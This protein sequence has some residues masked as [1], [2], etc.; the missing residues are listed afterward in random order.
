MASKTGLKAFD[1][2]Q[3]R[4]VREVCAFFGQAQSPGLKK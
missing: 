3:G 1:P 2:A 4:E